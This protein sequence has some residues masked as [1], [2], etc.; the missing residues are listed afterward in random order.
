M[1]CLDMWQKEKKGRQG[2]KKSDQLGGCWCHLGEEDGGLNWESDG[3][4]GE[5]RMSLGN[6]SVVGINRMW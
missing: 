3:G 6:I 4:N 2:W 5:E 1:A